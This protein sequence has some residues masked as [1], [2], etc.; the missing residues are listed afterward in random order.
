MAYFT[1]FQEWQ[2]CSCNTENVDARQVQFW[3][4]VWF[5]TLQMHEVN[6]GEIGR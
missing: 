3:K 5:D 1:R 6:V 2:Q 4:F